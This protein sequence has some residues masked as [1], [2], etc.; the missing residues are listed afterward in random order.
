MKI[1]GHR[2]AR[3]LAPENTIASFEKALSH[4]IDEVEVDLRVT[5]DNVVVLHHNRYLKDRSGKRVKISSSTFDELR[6][7]KTDL[8]TLEE[9]L[10]IRGKTPLYLEAKPRINTKPVINVLIKQNVSEVS[11]G[12]KNQ[13]TLKQFHSALPKIPCIV[14]HPWSGVIATHRARRVGAKRISMNQ[15][16]LWGGFIKAMTRSGYKLSAYTLNNPKKAHRWEKHGLYG[17]VTDYP[18]LFESQKKN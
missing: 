14:I 17:V 10:K 12:S 9:L 8:A 6:Q 7:H 16:W 11:I 13:K 18:D 15:L 4:H 3:G 5:N 1:I 2:G